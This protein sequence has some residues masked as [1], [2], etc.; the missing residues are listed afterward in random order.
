MSVGGE[1]QRAVVG[2]PGP[3]SLVDKSWVQQTMA[4][5]GVMF[6]GSMFICARHTPADLDR[7]ITAFDEAFAALAGEES[8]APAAEGSGRPARLPHP[9]SPAARPEILVLGAGSIGSR[10]VT[11]LVGLGARVTCT[12]PDLDRARS[13]D[14]QAAVPFDLDRLAG[15]DGIVVASPTRLH[16]E[17]ARAAVAAG[18]AVL[19]EK[20][21]AERSDGVD[22]LVAEAGSRLMVGYN[23]RLHR[24]IQELVASV[25]S[26]QIGSPVSV[27]LWFGSWLPDWRPDV[28]YRTTYSARADLGGGVLNDAIHELDLAV[29]LL[30][31]R[32]A[33]GRRPWS[34]AWVPSRS[35]W[36]TPSGPCWSTPTGCR[37]LSSWT[38]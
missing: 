32:P 36:R 8:V 26:G 3:D 24:P 11:N 5:H 29:W 20:P 33:G 30:R 9:V 6:N 21:L 19:V 37:S 12:D 27:R 1:P 16:L 4:E 22:A 10:H 28:D 23:L 38:T 35:T 7:A 34:I 14:A 18:A 15:Y 2:F 17:Q 25:E 31:S 13:T